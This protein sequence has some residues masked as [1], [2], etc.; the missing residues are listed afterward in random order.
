M[1]DSHNPLAE[2]AKGEASPEAVLRLARWLR[3][4]PDGCV[5]LHHD[6]ISAGHMAKG[7]AKFVSWA[8]FL[9]QAWSDPH[10]TKSVLA[11]TAKT[12]VAP[13]PWLPIGPVAGVGLAL[14]V[15]AGGLALREAR[16]AQGD[17]TEWANGLRCRL[18]VVGRALR[19]IVTG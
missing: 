3:A 8:P 9:P 17:S 4:N 12:A 7:L 11:I 6:R 14:V 5:R 1:I 15:V 19:V 13:T 16:L 2:V 10:G 18:S